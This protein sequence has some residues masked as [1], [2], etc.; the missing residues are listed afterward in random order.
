MGILDLSG[1]HRVRIVLGAALGL[2]CAFQVLGCASLPEQ[3]V[4]RYSFPKEAFVDVPK[5]AF[6]KIGLVRTKVNFNT[7]NQDW[8]ESSLCRNYFNKAALDLV[9]RAKERGAD[10]V[11]EIRSIVFLVDGKSEAYSQAECSDD[12][13]EGQVL[14]QGIAVKW[15]GDP[16]QERKK[17]TKAWEQ[18]KLRVDPHPVH[19]VRRQPPPAETA[20]ME[21]PPEAASPPEDSPESESATEPKPVS[22]RK[23]VSRRSMKLAPDQDE[24]PSAQAR[25]RSA[26]IAVPRPQ[27][28][29]FPE[30]D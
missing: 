14:A 9:K 12:G 19:R 15:D 30:A 27:D 3:K 24:V 11:V 8:E 28:G 29:L 1:R 10:A 22:Q 6:R 4:K 13:G 5:R 23:P 25:S 26:P 7:L 2:A 17:R 16:E 21:S 20:P 18:G